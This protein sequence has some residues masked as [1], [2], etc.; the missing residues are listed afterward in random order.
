MGFPMRW[1]AYVVLWSMC[2]GTA[3]AEV[4]AYSGATLI[5]GTGEPPIANATVL[6]END[7]ILAAGSG[8]DV[9]EGARVV[10]VT[11]TWIVPGLIDA[12]IHFMTSGRMYTRPAFFDLTDKVPYEEEVAWIK[13]HIPDTLPRVH[14][15][16]RDQRPV[17]GR[18]EP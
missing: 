2:C 6:V 3:L 16:G 1:S 11:G 9:P 4:T 14:V 10:D 8:V 18:T 17:L 5:D 13:A 7:R 12:H 15:L